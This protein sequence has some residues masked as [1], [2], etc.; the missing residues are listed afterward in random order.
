MHKQRGSTFIGL[1]TKLVV[2]VMVVVVVVRIIPVYYQYYSIMSTVK[3]LNTTS[4]SVLTSDSTTDIGILR[5]R[6]TKRLEINGLE[7]LK[8]GEVI[9]SPV[10]INLFKVRVKYQVIK[11]LVYN[12]SLLFDFDTTREVKIG[13]EN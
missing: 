11:P 6:I 13:S 4:S 5:E 9:I 1:L 7:D 8:A 3:S 2:L 10:S 12:I